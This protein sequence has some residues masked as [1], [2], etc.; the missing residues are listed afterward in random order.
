M[1]GSS[2]EEQKF[3]NN[4]I[5]V[6]ISLENIEFY[7]IHCIGNTR[8]GSKLTVYI[9]HSDKNRTTDI[10]PIGQSM[11]MLGGTL[12]KNIMI[13]NPQIRRALSTMLKSSYKATRKDTLQGKFNKLT[14]KLKAKVFR[15]ENVQDSRALLEEDTLLESSSKAVSDSCCAVKIALLVKPEK[16][17]TFKKEVID[18]L[19]SKKCVTTNISKYG[20]VILYYI[21]NL[22]DECDFFDLQH[23]LQNICNLDANFTYDNAE[24]QEDISTFL[25]HLT[26]KTQFNKCDKKL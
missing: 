19:K 15:E 13:L 3:Y 23:A 25:S 18:N 16:F 1:L 22:L 9:N 24:H 4:K 12:T 10:K 7:E 21:P 6:D 11:F 26:V 5:C 17:D 20:T 2:L 8:D 14:T